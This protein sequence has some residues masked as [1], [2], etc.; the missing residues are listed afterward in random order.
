MGFQTV[1]LRTAMRMVMQTD[2]QMEYPPMV[3]R[4]GWHWESRWAYPH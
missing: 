4:L 2:Y 1:F 3:T